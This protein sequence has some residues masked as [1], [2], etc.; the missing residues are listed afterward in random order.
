MGT[1]GGREEVNQPRMNGLPRRKNIFRMCQTSNW[2]II[3][4]PQ[5]C[6][7]FRTQNSPL[8][9]VPQECKVG[10][11]KKPLSVRLKGNGEK[12]HTMEMKEQGAKGSINGLQ[13]WCQPKF[14]YTVISDGNSN[15]VVSSPAHQRPL[16]IVQDFLEVRPSSG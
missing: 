7:S 5:R 1:G 9:L 8:F 6:N 3:F 12:D 2:V 14:I 13:L 15:A 10:L 4:T 16:S 11:K